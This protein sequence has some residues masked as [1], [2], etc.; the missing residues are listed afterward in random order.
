MAETP[1]CT[2]DE[3]GI[4]AP[5]FPTVL[6][7]LKEQYRAIYGQDIYL[8]NDSQ[9]GQLVGIFARAIHDCNSAC[10]SV[11]NAFSPSTAQ[12]TGLSSVV[13]INGIAR[14]LP[15]Y[16]SVDLRLIGQ[17][18]TTIVNG[19]ASDENNQQW[20]LPE[21][22]VIPPSG[23]I[24]VTA[25][26]DALGSIRA[27]AGSI[28]NIGTPTRGWQS[29]TNPLAAVEGAPVESDADLRRRQ[30]VSTA[31]PSLTVLDGIVGAVA[32]LN[33]V[34]RYKPYENDTSITDAN[35]IPSHTISLVVEGGDAQAI[36][37]AIM[38]KK[39]P[40]TGT[41]GTTKVSAVDAFGLSHWISFFRP[42]IIPVAVSIQIKAFAGYTTSIEAAIKQSIVD[43]I[44]KLDISDMVSVSRLYAPATL[45]NDSRSRTFEIQPNTLMIARDGYTPVAA[46]IVLAFNEA[47]DCSVEDIQIAIVP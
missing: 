35:G 32:S 25:T 29:V 28:T 2:I 9:D 10:V 30:S 12:G 13:K 26:A 39:T 23:E 27:Q 21:T 6:N 22:V 17:A 8:E 33:G 41:Y 5:D 15:S 38:T 42:T 18:G 16:S 47:A 14:A 44:R 36:G 3:T 37:D 11:Y 24:T 4:H 46:D 43:Y 7:W 31:L 1:I 40:G 19:N 34:T 20:N 45:Y